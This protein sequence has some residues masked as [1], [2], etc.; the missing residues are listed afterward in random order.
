MNLVP[1][2]GALRNLVEGQVRSVR[3]DQSEV[4]AGAGKLLD[5]LYDRFDEALQIVG[6]HEVPHFIQVDAVD[7]ELRVTAVAG[8]FA[9]KRNDRTVILHRA[10][11]PN[12]ADDSK[13][14]HCSRLRFL[15]G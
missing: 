4:R 7:E 10:F 14:L 9:V 5:F 11:R 15:I 8:A 12:A 3:C 13:G 2:S 6:D 1:K